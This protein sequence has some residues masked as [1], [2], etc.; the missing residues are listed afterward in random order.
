MLARNRDN[1]GRN[2]V[3]DLARIVEA[4]KTGLPAGLK[5]NQ[6][7]KERFGGDEIVD[8]RSRSGNRGVH[9]DFEVL[10][11]KPGTTLRFWKGVE[12]KGSTKNQPIPADQTPWAA[13]VQFHNGGCE[14]YSIGKL[15][16][17]TWYDMYI[18][19]GA[20]KTEWDIVAPTPTFEEW[21]TKDAK[22]QDDPATEFGLELK[23]KVRETRGPKAS[24]GEKRAAVNAVFSPTEEQ[25]AEFKGEVLRTLNE[26]LAQK[27]YWLTI[28]G[29]IAGDFHCE[30]YPR[31]TIS[32]ITSVT[33]RKELDI[34]FDFECPEAKFSCILRWGKGA[35]FSNIRIDARDT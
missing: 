28:Q 6:R 18:G 15:Y 3:E 8:A 27:H 9:Y 2:E 1:A 24:L 20:L 21:F 25:L 35:G 23:R 12:H 11:N 16:A 22:R 31:F 10:V 29:D 17:K 33:M 32:E 19:S 34:W 30:W 26:S 14:K 13:G 7:F 5:M 4:L